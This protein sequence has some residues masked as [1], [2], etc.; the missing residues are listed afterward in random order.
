MIH[1]P[2]STNFIIDKKC[3]S[4][5]ILV[6]VLLMNVILLV[7]KEVIYYYINL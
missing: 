1:T 6:L 3:K 7:L 5:S 4:F 2:V